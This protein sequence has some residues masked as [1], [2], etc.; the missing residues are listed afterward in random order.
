MPGPKDL[1]VIEKVVTRLAEYFKFPGFDK[2][3]IKQEGR[4]IGASVFWKFDQSKGK[5]EDFLFV[6]IRNGLMNLKTE[7]Y[8]NP[9]TKSDYGESRK[10]IVGFKSAASEPEYSHPFNDLEV[11]EISELIDRYIHPHFKKDYTKIK[12]GSYIGT[13][14]RNKI[15]L[16]VKR[17]YKLIMEDR[18]DD[19]EKQFQDR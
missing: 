5:L 8:H 15:L 7:H 16:E 6:A 9:R 4:L 1:E 3:D 2:D 12:E 14:R 19:L 18:V 13:V 17:I 10:A 11:E